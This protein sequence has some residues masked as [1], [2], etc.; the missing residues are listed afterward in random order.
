MTLVGDSILH[1]NPSA[2][3]DRAA[4]ATCR[5]DDPQSAWARLA[6]F[7]CRKFSDRLRAVSFGLSYRRRLDARRDW[8]STERWDGRGDGEPGSRRGAGRCAA[9]QADG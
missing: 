5:A 2:A 9:Q 4:G 8:G 1:D 7:F 6:E 3:V